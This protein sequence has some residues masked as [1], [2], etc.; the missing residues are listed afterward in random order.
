MN[1]TSNESDFIGY[2]DSREE[3]IDQDFFVCYECRAENCDHCIGIPC[4]CP[5]PI[6]M[7]E[8]EYSI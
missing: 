5:C 6:P 8:P 7:T 1:A 3:A 4:M 2:P